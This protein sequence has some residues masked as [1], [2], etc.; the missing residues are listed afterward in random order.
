MLS[1]L[2]LAA[3]ARFENATDSLEP[4]VEEVPEVELLD[5]EVPDV[6]L[7]D[8]AVPDVAVP[9]V[10]DPLEPEVLDAWAS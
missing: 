9:D 8:V 2:A 10:D 5:V 7:L 3:A 1:P 4:E 6:E